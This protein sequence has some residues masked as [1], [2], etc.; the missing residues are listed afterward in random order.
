M[1]DIY[2][3]LA[4]TDSINS[5]IDALSSLADFTAKWVDSIDG[6]MGVLKALGTLGLTVFSQQIAK[7]INTTISNF[8]IAKENAN[9]FNQAL[10]QTKEWQGIP[11][12]DEAQKQLL[13]YRQ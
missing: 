12:L 11:G 2:D 6:G 7:G 8:Q 4:D 5:I 9:Q 3:S 1:E 10:E 13:S